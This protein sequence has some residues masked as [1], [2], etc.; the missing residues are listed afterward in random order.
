MFGTYWWCGLQYE[1]DTG[2]LDSLQLH[3]VGLLRVEIVEA[4]DL[5]AADMGGTS[6]PVVEVFTEVNR[7]FKT[8]VVKANLKPKWHDE[9]KYLFV[10]EPRSQY[11]RVNVYDIDIINARS[12]IKGL[13]VIKNLKE[14]IGAEE[15][16]GRTQILIQPMASNSQKVVDDWY[17]L[18]TGD[19]ASVHGPGS[20]C[21]QVRLK[22]MYTPFSELKTAAAM[23]GGLIVK[24]V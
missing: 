20:G 12:L 3:S 4:R 7:K 6:D 17:D 8:K 9:V 2:P 21:G 1:E 24:V 19:W 23:H 13:N 10:Q 16:L 5:P 11:L 18:G 22:I 15:L 14:M